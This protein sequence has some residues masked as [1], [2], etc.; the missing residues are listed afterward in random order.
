MV[1]LLTICPVAVFVM[2]AVMLVVPAATAVAIPLPLDEPL[3]MVATCV[4]DELQ[5]TDCVTSF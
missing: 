5:L 1:W 4:F 2:V 3:L